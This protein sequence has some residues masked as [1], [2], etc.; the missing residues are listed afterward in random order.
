MRCIY[1]YE[2]SDNYAYIGLT[3]NLDKRN[4]AHITNYNYMKIN[5]DVKKSSVFEHITKTKLTPILKQLT[6]YIEVEEAIKMEE[7]YVEKYKSEGWNIL[8]KI[9][10]GSIGG[11]YKKWTY[12]EL[13]NEALKYQH[14]SEFEKNNRK[15]YSV[16]LRWKILDDIC[17]HMTILKRKNKW[18]YE[19]CKETALLYTTLADFMNNQENCYKAIVRNNWYNELCSHLEK[20]KPNG[21]WDIKENCKEEALKYKNRWEYQV[22]E[23]AA[24]RSALK[25]HW[26]DE[27]YPKDN[28]SNKKK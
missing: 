21:Y 3:Y 8:N 16:A 10:T 5:E 19:K 2:F 4:I 14:R 22:K 20:R 12:N 18:T 6:D 27:F 11:D 7:Y 26:L 9:K 25:N 13:K 23:V 17:E 24:Y 15:A 28:K 1:V